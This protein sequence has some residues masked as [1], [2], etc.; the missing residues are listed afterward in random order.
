ML[1]NPHHYPWCHAPSLVQD[2]P[3]G[4]NKRRWGV[5]DNDRGRLA[6]SSQARLVAD[7]ALHPIGKIQPQL[8][9][10]NPPDHVQSSR[11]DGSHRQREHASTMT[12]DASAR[13]R[14]LPSAARQRHRHLPR[15]RPG[16]N[17]AD[18]R[19]RTPTN[20][21]CPITHDLMRWHQAVTI[22]EGFRLINK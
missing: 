12:D 9:R 10:C 18:A 16:P 20:T 13:H 6:A 19:D 22:P 15:R 2:C 4:A 1:Q 8:I 3:T 11:W 7:E 21:R 14:Q 5:A 17:L